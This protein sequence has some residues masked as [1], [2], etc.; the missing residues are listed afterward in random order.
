MTNKTLILS[1]ILFFALI[2]NVKPSPTADYM[3]QNSN[4]GTEF[5]IAIPQN[6]IKS[7]QAEEILALYI[8]SYVD[9]R[10][11][12]TAPKYGFQWV[13]DVKA[14]EPLVLSSENGGA[15]YNWEII[16]SEEKDQMG[17]HI[18]SEDPIAV[19]VLN[20][21]NMSADGYLA[22][23]KKHFGKK[24]VHCS[25]YDFHEPWPRRTYR[26]G[27]FIV[28]AA[29]E[30]TNVTIRL[31]G[32]GKEIGETVEG[33]KIGETITVQ[34]D[35]NQTYMVRGNGDN[36]FFDLSG[37]IIEATKPVGVISFH[38][39]TMIP[40]NA[41]NGRDCL[42]EMLIPV[43]CYGKEYITVEYDRGTQEGDLV[44]VIASEDGT[45]IT[46]DSYK[47]GSGNKYEN[48][49]CE[50]LL[51]EGEFYEQNSVRGV[52]HWRANKPV[53]IMQYA[54][55]F[56]WDGNRDWD[57]LMTLVPP[58]KQFQ[59]SIVFQT[60]I[61]AGF[62]ENQLTLFAVGDPNDP[63]KKALNSI[64]FDGE[65]LTKNYPQILYNRIPNT[66]V[67]WVRMDIEQDAHSI[68]SDTKIAGNLN[69]FTGY[70]SYGA[71]AVMGVDKIDELDTLKPEIMSYHISCG[72][73]SVEVV[74]QRNDYE[75]LQRDQGLQD[76]F[77]IKESSY[78]YEL[79]YQEYTPQE[80]IYSHEFNLKII[81]A[82]KDAKAVFAAIDRAGNYH[83]DSVFYAATNIEVNDYA[84]KFGNL[85][86]N[87]TKK[88]NLFVKNLS[89]SLLQIESCSFDDSQTFEIDSVY[90]SAPPL[91]LQSGE[92]A[93]VTVSCL[94]EKE[95]QYEDSINIVT[96]CYTFK[97]LATAK[98]VAPNI[99]IENWDAGE[100]N[101]GDTIC[102]KQR[103]GRGLRLGN[104]GSD[105]L[106]IEGFA[107]VN[108]P[109]YVSEPTIPPA[110]I[111]IPPDDYVYVESICF[112]PID[113][114]VYV[115][116]VI[117]LND[118]EN[119]SVS[120]WRGQAKYKVSVER[121][122]E[123]TLFEI[124]PNPIE[125]DEVIF[126]FASPTT[127]IINVYLYDAKGNKTKTLI[128]NLSVKETVQKTLELGE[129]ADGL[130][131]IVVE[132]ESERYAKKIVL[133]R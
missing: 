97:Y 116:T 57:P 49:H 53:M 76:F 12:I 119:D 6:D 61:N 13:K 62:N 29:E 77:F 3:L 127:K 107:N 19:F 118:S 32:E 72:D 56:P 83:I 37:T 1:F 102:F 64:Y 66:N 54:Y 87:K 60:P 2:G 94:P 82:T 70:N 21:R 120:V 108:P 73:Y 89:D 8:S 50:A 20:S 71:P 132:T 75:G 28:V 14:F 68:I 5:H 48:G 98:G 25:Y 86:I 84:L 47:P 40:S 9:T 93:T 59:K 55:S 131:Y 26:G 95:T 31:K 39:R 129:V 117:V 24:Y 92:S 109:F 67:Y 112:A 80:A 4:M 78:N 16:N 113:S 130:Y 65:Q 124:A 22:I 46:G 36:V 128:K 115:D 133:I 27:G 121:N 123:A 100:I 90:P 96:P 91:S 104:T 105:T 114:G 43:E 11:V 111:A 34:L 106:T 38:Q 23:P 52:T 74:E 85:R 15:S 122:T 126:K 110:P 58:I 30:N 10:V 45:E 101:V 51:N 33:K 81:D 103:H 35:E 63:E 88:I 41:G 18:E 7:G 42:S 99:T 79:D 69:G 125:N 44:R 17:V